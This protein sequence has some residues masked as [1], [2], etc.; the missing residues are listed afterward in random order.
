MPPQDP[1]NTLE[2]VK[3]FAGVLTPLSVAA[4]GWFISRRLKRLELVQW[5]NQKLIEKRLAVYDSVA[6]LL[7]K[8]LCFYTWVG[9][10]KEVSPEDVVKAKREL[11]K[12]FNIYRHLFDDEVYEAYQTYIHV[13]FET[14]TGAGLDAKI[15]S[16]VNGPDGDRTSH[17]TYTWNSAWS[18]KFSEEKVVGKSEVRKH[19]YALMAVIRKSLG[20][21]E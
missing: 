13:L 18:G 7:N 4:L 17:C 20:V 16:N 3:L 6:P 19:Y 10:W 2:I 14:F 5:S 11:D 8:L 15:R 1:W 12:S 21:H 9:D